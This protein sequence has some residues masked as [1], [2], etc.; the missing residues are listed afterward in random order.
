MM[1]AT[2]YYWAFKHLNT[3]RLGFMRGETARPNPKFADDRKNCVSI[4]GDFY[5]LSAP[6]AK[7]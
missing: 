4:N 1:T 2:N 5:R 6:I 7:L 3:V